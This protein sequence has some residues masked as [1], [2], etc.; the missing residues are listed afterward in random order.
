MANLIAQGFNAIARIAVII[1]LARL[2]NPNDFGMMAMV[3]STFGILSMFKDFGL[4]TAT[5]QRTEVSEQQ[6]SVL[7]W[8]N[9]LVGCLLAT[10]TLISA[11]P[12]AMFYREPRLV[13]LCAA[14]AA[15][16][17]LEASGIQHAALLQR[18]MRFSALA[19]IDSASLIASS[20]L[21]VVLALLGTG[22]WALF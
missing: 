21:G 7:F 4:S 10:I 17:I 13:T 3:A 16:F 1:I 19:L 11:W 20:I 9:V 14:F 18:Q 12:A 15:T 8:I 6:L 2:L 5:V 22:Y